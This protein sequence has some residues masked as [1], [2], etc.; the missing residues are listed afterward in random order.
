MGAKE[1]CQIVHAIEIDYGYVL[2]REWHTIP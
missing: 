1:I 2:L